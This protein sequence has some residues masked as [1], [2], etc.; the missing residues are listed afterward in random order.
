[1]KKSRIN[2]I[3]YKINKDNIKYIVKWHSKRIALYAQHVPNGQKKSTAREGSALCGVLVYGRA[4]ER[5]RGAVPM[6]EIWNLLEQPMIFLRQKARYPLS[7]RLSR[8]PKAEPAQKLFAGLF[9]CHC[10]PFLAGSALAE[11]TP[12]MR[13]NKLP[14]DR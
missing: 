8:L 7:V 4:G 13:K 2:K 3:F 5:A 12:P 9:C 6:A 10:W 11:G 1:M 14:A